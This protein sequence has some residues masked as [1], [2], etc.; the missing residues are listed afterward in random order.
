M[1]VLVI[2]PPFIPIPPVLYGGLERIVYNLCYGLSEK[3]YEVNL[4]A[5]KNSLSFGGTTKYYKIYRYGKNLIGRIF[6][7]VEFQI[8]TLKLVEDVDIIHSFV[9]WPELHFF[10]NKSKRPIIYNHQNPCSFNTLK[11]ILKKNQEFGYLQCIS[12]NQMEDIQIDNL[13]KTFITYNCVDTNLFKPQFQEKDDYVMYLGRLNY[14][15]GVDIAVSLAKDSNMPL[16][17]AGPVREHEKG[18]KK[19]F[20]E[21]VKPYLNNQIK[22]IGEINDQQKIKFLSRSRALIVPNRWNEPFGIMNVEA[23]AC[24]TPII[25]SN[26]GSLKEIVMH[27]DTGYLCNDYGDLI[28]AMKNIDLFLKDPLGPNGGLLRCTSIPAKDHR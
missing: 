12:K 21:K 8:Q 19:L 28:E 4:L 3:G 10:L 14:N 7:W 23:L 13:E 25:G 22:Y 16:L 20:E 9:E 6:N 2:A 17:I 15:K 11:R 24:G 5:G 1:K 27:A 26:K 18:S